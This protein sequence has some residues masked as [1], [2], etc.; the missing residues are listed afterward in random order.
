MGIR[1]LQLDSLGNKVRIDVPNIPQQKMIDPGDHI[2]V[3]LKGTVIET[4]TDT[5]TDGLIIIANSV[6]LKN[7][8]AKEGNRAMDL[9]M[10]KAVQDQEEVMVRTRVAPSPS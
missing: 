1:Q 9:A 3:V 10:E 2:E 7:M 8:P 5:D 6:E 4:R